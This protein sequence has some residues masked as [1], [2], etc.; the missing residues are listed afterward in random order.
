MIIVKSWQGTTHY[1]DATGFRTNEYTLEILDG[2]GKVLAAHR[3]WEKVSGPE[4]ST[5]I[6]AARDSLSKLY[7][8]GG[9]IDLGS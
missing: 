6:D 2:T 7:R 4:E 5:Y 1:P 9:E 3:D 8:M